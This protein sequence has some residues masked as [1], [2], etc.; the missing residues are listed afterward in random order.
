MEQFLFDFASCTSCAEVGPHIA[1]ER[2]GMHT[3]SATRAHW[4][5]WHANSCKLLHLTRQNGQIG[6][7]GTPNRANW[8]IVQIG[9]SDSPNRA[10]CYIWHAKSYKLLHLA[11][12]IVQIA[13]G[14]MHYSHT[15]LIGQGGSQ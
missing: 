4:N 7:F 9:T 6:T 1:N 10:N 15:Q 5:I 3:G 14:C 8:K 12:Q 11:R 13:D 2:L